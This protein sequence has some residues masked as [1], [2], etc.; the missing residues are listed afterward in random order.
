MAQ[1]ET[2]ADIAATTAPVELRAAAVTVPL[3]PD[4][5]T[6]TLERRLAKVAPDKDVADLGGWKDLNTLRQI[7]QMSDRD[8]MVQALMSRLE[9]R[10][11]K[12]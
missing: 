6:G 7:Y 2:S 9:L 12:G 8:T 5:A 10:E 1:S 3:V 11:G 4:A